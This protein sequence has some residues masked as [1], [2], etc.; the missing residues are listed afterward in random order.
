MKSKKKNIYK[1]KAGSNRNQRTVIRNFERKRNS[2]RQNS[3]HSSAPLRQR[4]MADGTASPGS[5][6]L[7]P[8]V[9]QIVTLG[10]VY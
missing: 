8:G 7:R 3:Q 2:R 4:L 6:R 5:T 9:G 10:K 1:L